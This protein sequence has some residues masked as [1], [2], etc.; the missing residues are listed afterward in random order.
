MNYNTK[1]SFIFTFITALFVILLL[2]GCNRH[3]DFRG[4]MTKIE[5][6]EGCV[7]I[8]PNIIQIDSIHNREFAIVDSIVLFYRTIDNQYFFDVFNIKNGSEI[9]K[10]CH[11]GKGSGEYIALSPITHITKEGDDWRTILF[12][13]NE[14]KLI[15]WNISKSIEQKTT[16][17]DNIIDYKCHDYSSSYSA[18]YPI[19][20]DSL[21]VY[22]SSAHISNTDNITPSRYQVR[23]MT[24]NKELKEIQTFEPPTNID[25]SAILPE[26]YYSS[27]FCV[28]PNKKQ[29][30][31]VM[32]YHPQINIIDIET[33]TI[34]GYSFETGHVNSLYES[35]NSNIRRFYMRVQATNKYIFA[36]YDGSKRSQKQNTDGY[37][38]LHMYNWNGSMQ[39]KI[40]LEY[41][42][43][44]IFIDEKNNLLY[45][46]NANEQNV[47]CYHISNI[48]N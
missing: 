40:I 20:D 45:G 19:G 36:L 42:I 6:V 14:S 27:S 33:S 12:A 26:R 31:E 32:M 38:E 1:N 10:F 41:P 5:T 15:I 11:R 44:E 2:I 35:N 47:Y 3:N 21:L 46:V 29:F 24:L 28:R 30:A 9:G 48:T 8:Q 16:V 13:P 17:Y 22:I 23:S 43:H 37:K 18:L 39:K 25:R 34:K 4:G 7:H